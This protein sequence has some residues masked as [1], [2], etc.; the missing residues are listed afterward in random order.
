MKN[1]VIYHIDT[2]SN[3]LLSYHSDVF[4]GEPNVADGA[5]HCVEIYRTE[6]I[7]GRW[8]DN[9]CGVSVPYICSKRR[10]PK[11]PDG[12]EINNNLK[13]PP[14]WMQVGMKST[15]VEGQLW[16]FW[17]LLQFCFVQR[18]EFVFA[19]SLLQ[20]RNKV[21]VFKDFSLW[22]VYLD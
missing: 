8:N 15:W 9:Q 19:W 21:S 1:Y 20:V 3:D 4:P 7:T 6:A 12:Q 22:F 11:N 14:G 13:C 5:E 17:G 10:D 16:G 18:Q 2:Q